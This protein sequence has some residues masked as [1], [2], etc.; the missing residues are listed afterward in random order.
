MKF[1]NSTYRTDNDR[2][3]KIV[4]KANNLLILEDMLMFQ[5]KQ[6]QEQLKQP[7]S[8]DS[9]LTVREVYEMNTI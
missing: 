8:A 2:G 5:L 7:Y 4:I 1:T 9:K 6:V 3:T